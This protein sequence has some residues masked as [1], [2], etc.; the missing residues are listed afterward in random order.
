[1]GRVT[2][3][4]SVVLV[5]VSP[6]TIVRKCPVQPVSTIAW[7]QLGVDVCS[8]SRLTKAAVGWT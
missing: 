6:G 1:L 8:D 5:L 7:R 2:T 4:G 3:S